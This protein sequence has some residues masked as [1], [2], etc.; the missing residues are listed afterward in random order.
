MARKCIEGSC[1]SFGEEPGPT[2]WLGLLPT[3]VRRM[4][5]AWKSISSWSDGAE[6]YGSWVLSAGERWAN[7]GEAV[8]IVGDPEPRGR[9]GRGGEGLLGNH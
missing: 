6:R 7:C 1:R 3:G 9:H 4:A 2:L 5:L 8:D